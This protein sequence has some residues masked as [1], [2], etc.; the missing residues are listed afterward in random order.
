MAT[1][2]AKGTGLERPGTRA[3]RGWSRGVG[4]V[5]RRGEAVPKKDRFRAPSQEPPEVSG[6]HPES[7]SVSCPGCE[8]WG[9]GRA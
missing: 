2:A 8:P 7:T 4:E 5:E 3:E 1:L 9:R 6:D